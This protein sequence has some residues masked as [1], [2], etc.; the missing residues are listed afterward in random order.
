MMSVQLFWTA[1]TAANSLERGSHRD[2]GSFPKRGRNV[3]AYYRPT[4]TVNDPTTN[5]YPIQPVGRRVGRIVIAQTTRCPVFRA[6]DD[7]SVNPP[8]IG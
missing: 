7:G 6:Q 5:R 3:N 2:T 1:D 8:F 4:A